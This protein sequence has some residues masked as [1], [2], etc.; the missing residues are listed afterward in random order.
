MYNKYQSQEVMRRL[1]QGQYNPQEQID[2]LPAGVKRNFYLELEEQLKGYDYD[3]ET[4]ISES[5]ENASNDYFK[6]INYRLKQS[7]KNSYN[8][9]GYYNTL[10]KYTQLVE[11]D[12]YKTLSMDSLKEYLDTLDVMS[13]VSFF[14]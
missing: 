14:F 3:S 5:L 7:I 11:Q 6:G 1:T 4:V 2:K 13:K 12:T 9:D 10:D 8:S